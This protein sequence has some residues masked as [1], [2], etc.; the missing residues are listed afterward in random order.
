MA[1]STSRSTPPPE[2]A[3]ATER[4]GA[5]RDAERQAARE[6]RQVRAAPIGREDAPDWWGTDPR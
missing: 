4:R 5:L 6:R 2:E 1:S 3:P